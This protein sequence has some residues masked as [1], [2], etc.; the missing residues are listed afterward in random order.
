[1]RKRDV[2][3]CVGSNVIDWQVEIL[4]L[5]SCLSNFLFVAAVVVGRADWRNSSDI[6]KEKPQ[7]WLHTSEAK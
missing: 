6:S 2:V 7:H 4:H 3:P 5:D 1:M